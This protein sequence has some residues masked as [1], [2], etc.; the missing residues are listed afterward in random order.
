MMAPSLEPVFS[1]R[2]YIHPETA[3]LGQTS[4]GARIIANVVD[5][6]IKFDI[7]DIEAQVVPPGGDWP[8]IDLK[9]EC[10]YIDARARAKTDLGEVYLK[11]TGVLKF[12]EATRR[13]LDKS[14]PGPISSNFA[15]TVWFTKLDIVTTDERLKWL[16]TDF[17][18]GQ[19]RWHVDEK[20]LAAEYRV[21]KLKN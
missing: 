1:M 7:S 16:E 14:S 20:G 21:Y 12:D 6:F 10:I 8:L 4:S 15:E 17:L 18:V 2:E 3:D 5:G 11:Y 13:L 19:G 9:A